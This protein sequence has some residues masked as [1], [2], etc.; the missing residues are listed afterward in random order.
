MS[1][2]NKN[3]ATTNPK[4]PVKT[5]TLKVWDLPVRIFH[6]SLVVLFIAAYATNSLGSDYFKY[7]LWTGYTIIVLVSFRI[8]WGVVGT[9]YARFI[10]FVRNPIVTAKYAI[11]FFK[12]TDARYA[13]HNPLG[14]VMVVALL[15]TIL[16]Q[17]LTGLFTN[18]EILN[19]GPLYTYVSDE[20]SL[21]LTSVH[22]HLFYWILGAIVMHIIA[23]LFHLTF[24]RENIIAAML[25]GKKNG[26]GLEGEKS[27]TSSRAW[28][29]IIIILALSL[30]L[31]WVVLHAPELVSE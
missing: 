29:A 28:L 10:N 17:G 25:T 26:E 21:K 30:L 6:W 20:L 27:I 4:S 31:A 8:L 18:D 7:H 11:S 1:L 2:S 19:L 9:H 24:K 16:I 22:R 23:V 14:A 3:P 15:F 12:K 5:T 13:G